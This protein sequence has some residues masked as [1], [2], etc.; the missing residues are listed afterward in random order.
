MEALNQILNEAAAG[1]AVVNQEPAAAKTSAAAEDDSHLRAG[2]I[3]LAGCID[4]DNS[5][6]TPEGLD[7]PHCIDLGVPISKSYSSSISLHMFFVSM[8]A[9]RVFVMGKNDHG[10][11]GT[12]A[13]TTVRYPVEISLNDVLSP[14]DRILSIA[15]GRS[16]SLLLLSNG[17]VWGTGANSEG[18]LGLGDTKTAAK[19]T[20]KFVKLPLTRI[21]DISCGH[22][23]SLAC[24]LDG[25]LFTWGHPQYGCLGYGND[26][27]F[28]KESGKGPA[29]QVIH[30]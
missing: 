11:C 12:G 26:G 30:S 14:G 17:D 16:H 10:Q 29:I 5:S 8:D 23:H 22:D 27:S 20:L 9:K 24:D 1:S 13:V 21:R 2:M 4:F 19:D 25:K 3:L 18:Q 6:K 15:T 28:I 7:E